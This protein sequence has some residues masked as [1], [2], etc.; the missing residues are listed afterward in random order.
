MGRAGPNWT[1]LW[2]WCRTR[3]SELRRRRAE[4]HRGHPRAAGD[5]EDPGA[6]GLGP[7][8]AAQGPG[9]RGG[10]ALRYLSGARHPIHIAIGCTATLQP[11]GR[12]APCWQNAVDGRLNPKAEAGTGPLGRSRVCRVGATRRRRPRRPQRQAIWAA[13]SHRRL[14][15]GSSW[16]LWRA[17]KRLGQLDE[18][19]VFPG[20]HGRPGKDEDPKFP[21][22]H[23]HPPPVRPHGLQGRSSSWDSG[24]G[25]MH[26]LRPASTPPG[27]QR[28]HI[29]LDSP[30]FI[31]RR[32]PADEPA[33]STMACDTSSFIMRR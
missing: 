17:F 21:H 23:W 7:P 24:H 25:C 15:T 29:R 30:D 12:C 3:V 13:A 27:T 20:K 9:A 5:P 6:P 22:S 10:A 14:A 4:D 18:V 1:K 11:D 28:P 19:D 33:Q 2:I 16:A 32:C 8:A 31:D 26:R